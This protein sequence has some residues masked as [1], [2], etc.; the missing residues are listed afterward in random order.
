MVLLE[1]QRGTSQDW[2]VHK[3]LHQLVVHKARQGQDPHNHQGAAHCHTALQYWG[4]QGSSYPEGLLVLVLQLLG[5]PADVSQEDVPSIISDEEDS[6]QVI[7]EE[8]QGAALGGQSSK[9][10]ADDGNEDDGPQQKPPHHGG[11]GHH[12][13]H[14]HHPPPPTGEPQSTQKPGGHTHHPPL[15][16]HEKPDRT[17]PPCQGSR[18]SRP[19]KEESSQ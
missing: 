17:P 4:V 10:H 6:D 7:D 12:H 13:H 2:G 15:P 1:F 18:P 3:A 16:P 19:P 8:H 5:S 11:G 9:P 14:H